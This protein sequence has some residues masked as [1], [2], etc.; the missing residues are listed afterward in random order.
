MYG[1]ARV[2]R[3]VNRRKR[4]TPVDAAEPARVAMGENV[5][6]APHFGRTPPD[7]IEAV[8]ADR[9]ALLHVRFAK[10][11]GFAEGGLAAQG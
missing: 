4:R 9:P 10:A 5:D 8:R 3:P 6:L 2:V 7:E 11:R 1:D